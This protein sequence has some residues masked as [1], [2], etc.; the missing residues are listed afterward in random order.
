M[1]DAL[2]DGLQPWSDLYNG[3]AAVEA[4]VLFGHL[5]G[6]LVAG[7][8]AIATD[9]A[10]LRVGN[11]SPGARAHVLHELD[12]IHRPVL[13]A[14][15]VVILTGI[16][17]L[18]SDVL[19]FLPSWVFW[20][21]MS[22]FVALLA[23]GWI[24][25]RAGR[26]LLRTSGA[27][28]DNGASREADT[29]LHEDAGIERDSGGEVDPVREVDA[30]GGVGSSGDV[31]GQGETQAG[32]E[33]EGS[34]KEDDGWHRLRNASIRSGALWTATLLFGVILTAV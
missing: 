21:K 23:N 24:L 3:S 7:G 13:A 4:V 30:G 32:D 31:G 1:L 22:L 27:D 10:V 12:R 9:R 15:V 8:F 20:L 29:G 34:G 33:D 14:L 18:F 6:I 2:A 17:M 16:A 19:T 5:A 26:R 28:A 25:E 11:A